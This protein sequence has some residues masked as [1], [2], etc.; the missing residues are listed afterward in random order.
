MD[1]Q[2]RHPPGHDTSQDADALRE[3][4]P[5]E[6]CFI[7]YWDSV[8]ERIALVSAIPKKTLDSDSPTQ[9]W[10]ESDYY[11]DPPG[12]LDEDLGIAMTAAK[13]AALSFRD[14]R[15]FLLMLSFRFGTISNRRSRH[16]VIAL[17][18]QLP[19]E[20]KPYF[21]MRVVRIR[22][23]TP[24]AGLF[25]TISFARALTPHVCIHATGAMLAG[26]FLQGCGA[27]GISLSA[28]R[29]T[30]NPGLDPEVALRQSIRQARAVSKTVL[31]EG[32]VE[33]HHFDACASSG[34]RFLSGPVIVKPCESIIGPLVMPRDKVVSRI[35]VV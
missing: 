20:L 11:E 4:D 1:S 35:A 19:P 12:Q 30:S 32:I 27:S 17:V 26:D 5:R 33:R 28:A 8:Q 21:V 7:H 2:Y 24:T 31:V 14:Q 23:G 10:G 16:R 25:D 9:L 13:A 15:R 22:P 34:V 18:E 29:A 6:V 3:A